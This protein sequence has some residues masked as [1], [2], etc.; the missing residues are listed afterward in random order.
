[1]KKSTIIAVALLAGGSYAS[2]QQTVVTTENRMGELIVNYSTPLQQPSLDYATIVTPMLCGQT[3]TLRFEPVTV[4]GRRNAKKLKRYIALNHLGEVP[5]YTPAKEAP[6]TLTG[7]VSVPISKY[8]WAAKGPLTFATQTECEG[9]CKSEVVNFSESDPFSYRFP[10]APVFGLVP[11]NTGKA[12][13]LEKDYPVLE[14]I[15]K[16]RPY[17]NSRILRKEKGALYVHFPLDKI[18]LRRDF[19][20]NDWRLDRICDITSQ[21]MADNTSHVE[22]IQIIGMASIEGSVAHNHWLAQGRGKALKDYVRK[23]VPSV[24][25][26]MFDVADGCEAW[27]EFRD[28]LSDVRLLKQG[29]RLDAKGLGV[30]AYDLSLTDADLAQITMEELDECINIIDNEPNLDRREQRL[31]KLNGGKTYRFM[32]RTLPA[33]QRNSGY[34]RIYWD[35]IP[36]EA[37]KRINAAIEQMQRGDYA[38]A[39]PRLLAEKEDPRAWN[40][41][42]C[43]QA[44]TG[45]EAEAISWFKKAVAEGNQDAVKNLQQLQ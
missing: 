9:C 24:T 13:A 12:G 34:L 10:F 1:M 25:D 36:D 8:P 28:Q 40:A 32:Q 29:K 42:G 39:L 41:I 3:D 37:A 11:D 33:D 15:S 26:A 31:R 16:Y 20:D 4:R 14:H 17:D 22:K 35:Y 23:Q 43:C 6:E 21:I 45:N 2:A 27:S 19:R 18:T 30:E 38:G 44:M 7:T 5:A